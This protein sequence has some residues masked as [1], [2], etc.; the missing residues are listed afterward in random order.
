[1]GLCVIDVIIE[2]QIDIGMGRPTLEEVNVL[3][4]ILDFIPML[5]TNLGR[6]QLVALALTANFLLTNRERREEG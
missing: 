6:F 3:F 5:S 2:R 1:V 4:V